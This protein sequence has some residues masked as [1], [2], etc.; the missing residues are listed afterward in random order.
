MIESDKFHSL[1]IVK[2]ISE[3]II[4]YMLNNKFIN[5]YFKYNYKLFS[6]KYKITQCFKFYLFE[7]I[8]KICHKNFFDYKYNDKHQTNKCEKIIKCNH[9]TECKKKNYKL[10]M[11]ECSKYKKKK[12][13]VNEIY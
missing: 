13:R 3:T 6:K 2:I 4:N 11:K 1:I 5:N 7:H 9:C 12:I 10:W 8:I